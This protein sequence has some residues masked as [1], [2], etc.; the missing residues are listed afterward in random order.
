[1]SVKNIVDNL[2]EGIK[3]YINERIKFAPYDRTDTAIVKGISEFGYVISYNNV[4]YSDIKTIG[5]TCSINETV[6]IMIPQNN[7]NNIFILKPPNGDNNYVSNDKI[8]NSGTI[9]TTGWVADAKQLN[10]SINNT[11]AWNIDQINNNLNNNNYILKGR[12][13]SCYVKD[14]RGTTIKPNNILNQSVSFG[15]ITAA[16]VG[17]P[18]VLVAL[19]T[20][21]P[22]VDESTNSIQMAINLNTGAL[23]IR[24][25]SGE[26]W[27]SW[28]EK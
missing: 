8:T 26:T 19:M 7:M 15:M 1:M 10:P 27:G 9:N 20:I 23:Y 25:G 4:L 17:L 2:M 22:W 21:K 16:E 11:L 3:F 12:A 6:K 28:V 18:G 5:G 24:T 13:S 14:I